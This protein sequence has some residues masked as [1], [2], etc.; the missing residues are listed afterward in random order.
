MNERQQNVGQGYH[1]GGMFTDVL[2]GPDPSVLF[3]HH[4][5]QTGMDPA[6]AFRSATGRYCT[7][8]LRGSNSTLR[9]HDGGAADLIAV[10]EHYD[11]PFGLNPI[12]ARRLNSSSA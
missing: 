10:V 4:P 8:P 7:T 5:A 1:E 9:I 11:R 2:S 3:L 6:Y 12:A